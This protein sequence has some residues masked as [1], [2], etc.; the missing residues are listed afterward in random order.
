MRSRP[1]RDVRLRARVEL[2]DLDAQ[3]PELWVALERIREHLVQRA[4]VVLITDAIVC[5]GWIRGAPE[6][7][8]TDKVR[9]IAGRPDRDHPGVELAGQLPQASPTHRLTEVAVEDDGPA[10]RENSARIR[11]HWRVARQAL[12]VVELSARK[13][14]SIH[15]I[16]AYRNLQTLDEEVRDGRLEREC[17]AVHEDD[18]LRREGGGVAIPP[19]NRCRL[20]DV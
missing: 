8:L 5:S 6:R 11:E 14:I 16:S 20:Q 18:G 10:G 15:V 13:R 19:L 1:A 4:D 7:P 17:W 3:F 9:G 12:A 2:D